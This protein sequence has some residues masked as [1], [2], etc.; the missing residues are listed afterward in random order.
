[1]SFDAD[2]IIWNNLTLIEPRSSLSLRSNEITLNDADAVFNQGRIQISGVA[3]P[4]SLLLSNVLFDGVKYHQDEETITPNID[5]YLDY[6]ESLASLSIDKL[7]VNR[8]QWIQLQHEPY[9]Q[10]SGL[11]VDV[12]GLNLKQKYQWGMWQGDLTAS[13][14]SI[15][16][17]T[18]I[19]TQA[20]M[21][22]SSNQGLW[23]LERFF[24]PFA[25]GY[26]DAKANIDFV[27]ASKPWSLEVSFDGLPIEP[28]INNESIGFGV[29]G[30]A[31]GQI[32]LSGLAADDI[33]A[34]QT[35]T[36]SIDT[37]FRNMHYR[38][39][40]KS[41]HLQKFN[42]SPLNII[43]QRGQLDVKPFSIT[44]EGII[45]GAQGQ[46]DLAAQN[47]ERL[48]LEINVNCASQTTLTLPAFNFEITPLG[49]SKPLEGSEHNGSNN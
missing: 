49:C 44:G 43:A 40:E 6:L 20:L 37:T 3:T 10:I 7:K 29:I 39:A 42:L 47:Q 23:Q 12:S 17:G 28:L 48:I 36:G 27:T 21:E 18:T 46:I 2:S 45:G 16:Y 11:N 26:L 32:T 15:S 4:S 30:V 31:D 25:Q 5:P 24:V 22:A 13:A 14:N 41:E 8:G 33:A 35:V 34:R 1:M 19:A 9:W 38:I